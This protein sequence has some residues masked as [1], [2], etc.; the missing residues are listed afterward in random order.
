MLYLYSP[1]NEGK[2]KAS[3]DNLMQ[4]QQ[5]PLKKIATDGPG[6]VVPM[7]SMSVDNIQGSTSGFSNMMGVSNVGM[8]SM[9]R[10]LSNDNMAGRE[11]GGQ[12]WKAS[13]ILAQAWK[14]DIDVGQL[15]L[16]VF[17]LFGESVL[18]FIPKPEA[19]IFL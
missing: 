6:G 5:P 14:E 4:Q 9:G 1:I 13:S 7:N 17:E 19:C 8:S 3:T 12:Q 15:L 11:V 16:P 10:Q 2:R 18:S